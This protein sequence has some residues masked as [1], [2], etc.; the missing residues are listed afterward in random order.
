MSNEENK[1]QQNQPKGF[2]PK[3][4]LIWL[5]IL[6]AIIG[7]V[8]AQSG[9]IAP[10]QR[11]LSSVDD[12]ISAAKEDRIEKAVIQSDPKGGEE[13]YV[14]NGKVLNPAFE[15]DE[16]QYK[17]LPFVVKGRITESEYKDL[18]SL[19][20]SRLLEEPSSTIWTD[21]LFS[22]LP[23]LLIIGLLYFLFVLLV[24][25]FI[26]GSAIDLNTLLITGFVAALGILFA[27]PTKED[28]DN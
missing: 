14:V 25:L 13:W 27:L 16:N 10:S 1:E 24:L 3:V 11:A 9:E 20:G 12:L 7:L 2:N 22:L 23:F 5:A 8:M 4:L 15:V 6:A 21:L 28:T 19:L 17:T 18:R 26:G